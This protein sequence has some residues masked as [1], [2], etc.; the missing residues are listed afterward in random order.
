MK[1]ELGLDHGDNKFNRLRMACKD[2]GLL[3]EVKQKP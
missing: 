3:I 2:I 1:L